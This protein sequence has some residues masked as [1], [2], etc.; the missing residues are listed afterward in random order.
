M[1]ITRT[2]EPRIEALAN[3]AVLRLIANGVLI[4][5]PPILAWGMNSILNRLSSIESALQQTAVNTATTE[6][7][8][9]A[10]EAIRANERLLK[11]EFEVEQVRRKP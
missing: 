11:V 8:I 4:A 5:A 10:L 1:D 6:H 3:S 9:R 2:T 7:R